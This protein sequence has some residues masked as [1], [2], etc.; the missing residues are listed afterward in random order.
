VSR[1]VLILVLAMVL[2]PWCLTAFAAST[3]ASSVGIRQGDWANYVGSPPC[4]EY[5]WIYVSFLQIEGSSV[6]ISMRY[7]IR[8][9]YRSPDENYWPDH[10]RL[11]TI[12][13]KSGTNNFFFFLVP[14]NLTVG[15]TVSGPVDYKAELR[16]EGTEVRKYAGAKRTIVYARYEN[17][18]QTALNL[19]VQGIFYWDRET[20]LLV[21]DTAKVGDFYVT[22]QKLTGTNL[23][24][25]D[26]TDWFIDNYVVVI[27]I[28][29]GVASS[30]FLTV[31]IFRWK[32]DTPFK[33]THPTI[34]KLL[35]AS[36]T[37][38]LVGGFVTMS[39][40]N[41]AFSSLCF[42]LVPLFFVTGIL[43][44]TGGWVSLGRNGLVVDVGTVL[45]ASAVIL[46]GVTVGFAT[47][48]ELGALVPYRGG[49]F[50]RGSVSQFGLA[51]SEVEGVFFYPYGWLAATLVTVV[52]SL[53]VVGF[54]Y[55]MLRR[56]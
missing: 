41:Q 13:T 52:L 46:A 5:E 34:G 22:S 20:G 38:F 19:N 11:M 21:E 39:N 3:E 55:K 50:F 24:Q 51:Y 53:A 12:D 30:A 28:V 6:D 42:A 10:P 47:Y 56:L 33:V 44:Y 9:Q 14:P 45:I 31:F 43:V 17:R 8:A 37:L 36:G 32:K 26:L 1:L 27:L 54:C 7:D 48:R 35:I 25:A 23:W 4:E 2:L 16:I 15:D 18:S 29:S 49:G 40:F